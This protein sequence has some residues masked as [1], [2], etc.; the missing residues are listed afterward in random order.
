M[1]GRMEALADA[2]RPGAARKITD[3]QVEAVV[4][5]T[6][7]ERRR[8][9]DSHWSTRTMA[10]ETG[11]SQSSVSRIWRA[12]GL[13]PHAVET[14]K[15]STDPEF[16][17][18]VRDVVGLYMSPPEHALVLAMDEKLQIQAWTAPQRLPH[19]ARL[20]APDSSRR[21]SRPGAGAKPVGTGRPRC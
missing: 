19:G 15:L 7:T 9:Q 3:E 10:A 6:L 1:D 18:K 13:K 20:P 4:T 21:P 2:P 17:G 12:L 5:R 8:G 16:I 14:W 11:L